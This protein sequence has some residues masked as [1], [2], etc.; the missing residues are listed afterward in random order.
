MSKPK[1]YKT[2]YNGIDGKLYA[3]V[4]CTSP[5]GKKTFSTTETGSSGVM[6]DLSKNYNTALLIAIENALMKH[7]NKGGNSRAIFKVKSTYIYYFGQKRYTFKT[8]IL[9]KHKVQTI[10]RDGKVFSNQAYTPIRNKYMLYNDLDPRS[11]KNRID[12]I[13]QAR[14]IKVKSINKRSIKR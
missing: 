10:Y 3:I 1:Y 11:S 6:A 9:R 14:N 7:I 2:L 8:R 13:I 4:R 5:K 12:P